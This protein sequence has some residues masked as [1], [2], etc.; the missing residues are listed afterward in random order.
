MRDGHLE[1]C[2]VGAGPRGLA[3]LER[4]CANAPAG[5]AVTG[6]TVHVAD[7]HPPGAGAVWRTDQSRLLLMNTIASQVTVFTDASVDMAG[8]LSPGPSLYEWANYLVLMGPLE[9]YEAEVLAEAR[10][11][12]PDS[13]PSRAFYGHYLTWAFRRIVATA[14]ARVRI[15]VHPATATSVDDGPGGRQRVTLDDGTV[16][17]GLD[18]VVLAQ[19][20]GAARPTGRERELGAFAAAHG[21]TYLAPG[22]PADADL[23]GIRPGEAVAL[24][25]LGLNFFDHMALLT[26]GRGGRF[27]RRLGRLV[28]VPSGREPRLYA[29]SRRGLP[30]HSR[31]RN[32]KGAHGRHEPL[33]LTAERVARLRERAAAGG[34]DFAREV[35]PLVAKEV[36]TVYYAAL[37]AGRSCGCEAARLRRAFLPVPHGS[38]E[39]ARVLA[40]FGV[41]EADR[42]DWAR[43]ADPAADRSF[44]DPGAH[45]RWL[46]GVL[47]ADVAAAAAGNVSGPL[48]AALD[49][50]RDLRNEI[51]LLV[52]HGGLTGRSHRD[53]LERWYTPLNAF[54]SI[55]PPAQ[56]IEELVALIEAGV[57]DVVGPQME[58]TAD[59]A[60]GAFTV[61][62]PR[63]AGSAVRA[64]ALVEARLPAPDLRTSTDP[65]LVSLRGAG[66]CRPYVVPGPQGA[67]YETGGLAVTGRPYR[68]LDAAGRAHPRRFAYGVPTEGV[69]WVTAAGVRPGVNSVTLAD[70]DAIA[71]AVLAPSGTGRAGGGD[72]V[73]AGGSAGGGDR[74][75][76][77]GGDGAAVVAAGPV[78]AAVAAPG[79]AAASLPGRPAVGPDPVPVP[80]ALVAGG[81]GQ[82]GR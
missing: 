37:L 31:G 19:G 2:I 77:R 25:G 51:R 40:G 8:R 62:S 58:V 60:A 48:K 10:A 53:D 68:V 9:D 76:D 30:Y 17:T 4:L 55:G 13:Y 23:S 52:D 29:S 70:A 21:L 22:N 71:L 59:A 35:W 24:R 81:R 43:L 80:C 15:V 65:L 12:T 38:A 7:P 20:H 45:R 82:G 34:L 54:L 14:P 11:L 69:H 56:R 66:G 47:R 72:G 5:G 78:R 16:L 1:V 75:S 57:V 27:E 61:S 44:D 50:L 46:L 6:V 33:V 39:E 49:A 28:Y 26:V 63:V 18:A 64:T 74:G 73:S 79:P 32:E 41:T 36:E 42:W 67:G 3:V